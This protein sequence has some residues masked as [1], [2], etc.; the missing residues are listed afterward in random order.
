MEEGDEVV[1]L[2]PEQCPHCCAPLA[3]DDP[4]PWR[5]QVLEIPPIESRVTEYQWHQLLCAACGVETRAPWPAGV[6][7]GP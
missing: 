1:M 3:G 7:S 5:H 6:P 2:K 4:T